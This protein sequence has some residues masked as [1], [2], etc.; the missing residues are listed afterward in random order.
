MVLGIKTAQIKTVGDAAKKIESSDNLYRS[1]I[2]IL[3][4]KNEK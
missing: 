3:R 2:V 1:W 4:K